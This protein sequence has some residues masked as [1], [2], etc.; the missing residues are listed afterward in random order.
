MSHEQPLRQSTLEEQLRVLQEEN[1]MQKR[2]V[3]E[4]LKVNFDRSPVLVSP[5]IADEN[6]VVR[7]K[8]FEDGKDNE[9]TVTESSEHTAIAR[10]TFTPQ[11]LD[12]AAGSFLS[13]QV[14]GMTMTRMFNIMQQSCNMIF[15]KLENASAR[16]TASALPGTSFVPPLLLLN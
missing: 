12:K 14:D 8:E 10:Q 13:S 2:L 11:S 6:K 3:E 7:S 15:N 1:Q 16:G 5:V 4:A 9:A